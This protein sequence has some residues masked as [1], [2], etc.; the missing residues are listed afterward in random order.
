[1]NRNSAASAAYFKY[2]N[3]FLAALTYNFFAIMHHLNISSASNRAHTIGLL[4]FLDICRIYISEYFGKLK[5]F[6]QDRTVLNF[7]FNLLNVF[8]LCTIDFSPRF[9]LYFLSYSFFESG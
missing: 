7:S 4:I 5:H 6:C 1:M 3:T 9:A 8:D 2:E